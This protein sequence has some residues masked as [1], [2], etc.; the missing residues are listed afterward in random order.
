MKNNKSFS[1]D[2]IDKPVDEIDD[3]GYV[4]DDINNNT[5]SEK[6]NDLPD[7]THSFGKRFRE[8]MADIKEEISEQYR[9]N[10]D[11][12]AKDRKNKKLRRQREF[13]GGDPPKS[14]KVRNVY[15]GIFAVKKLFS[16]I[17]TTVFSLFLIFIL[18]GTIVGTAVAV[19]LLDFM[20]QMPGV[21][22]SEF[23][24]NFGSY[25]YTMNK[26]TEEYELVYKATTSSHEIRIPTNL[27]E[28]PD[29]V[30]FAFVCI[31]D[32]RF[33]SHEGVDFKRT[34]GA[35]IN[36]ALNTLGIERDI[37]GGS[38]ITQQLIKNVT[39]DDAKTWDRKMREIF[40][41][42]KFEK[43]YTKDDILSAYL[44][45]IYFSE[46]DDYQMYGIE[47]ASIG[48][49]GK[50]ASEL[51]IAEAAVLAAIP[52]APNDYNPTIDFELNTK[53]KNTCL[54]KMFELGVI[55]ADQ[56]EEAVAQPILL[57]TMPGFKEKNPDYI[58]L[59]ESDDD[60]RNP[61]VTSWPVDTA[62]NEFAEY[63]MEVHGL[64]RIE[65]GRSMFN[66][67]GYKLYL[68]AD[69]ELQ[70]HLDNKFSTWYHFPEALSDADPDTYSE[71]ERRVQAALAVMD[72]E[73]H[74]LGV[75]GQIGPK[76]ISLGLNRAT[77]SH[78]QPGST[79]K[80]VTTYGYALEN[81]L[82][83]WSSHFYDI[84]L[85]AGVAAE[86][87]WPMNYTGYP[88]KGYYPVDYFLKKS[89]NTLPAQIVNTYGKQAVFD[90]AT[91]KLHLDLDP[92][93][94][95]NY[96]P[97]CVGGT[98]HGP[99]MVNLANAYMPYGNGGLYYKA[100][101]IN[102]AVDVKT[103]ETIID[104]EN[105]Q[106]EQAVSEDTAY[107]MNKLLRKVITEGT[108]TAAQL[109]NVPIAG[110]TGTTENWRDITF[111]GLTPDTV[112][113]LWIGYDYGMNQE[114]IIN[115]NSAEIWRDV[116]GYYANNHVIKEEFPDCETVI[117][118][119]RYCSYSGKIATSGCPGGNH[120]YYKSTDVYCNVH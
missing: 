58:K 9:E 26:E 41:A 34:S 62:I 102:K 94:D 91:Q 108:G 76:T 120:G 79:I 71:D 101:I 49:F 38:T 61:E 106:G 1:D 13:Y 35:I 46:I 55:S 70:A 18:T 63:L 14:K 50:T 98:S 19:Y 111:V 95:L 21:V 56:Y 67:G 105:R 5:E 84:P 72:Y 107:I 87:E 48:Y 53:R 32:E 77:S 52:K 65:E 25:I 8:R 12:F 81:D 115:S 85:A 10:I 88:S 11:D 51:T 69:M 82:I 47:A 30:K 39:R 20:D 7:G 29:H 90:F 24:Q 117:K 3:T 43:N 109:S 119:A 42:M 89:L 75:A 40:T 6:S 57:T 110:K 2:Y 100:S 44:N 28:L 96:S 45:E 83:T 103:G 112:S 80:P 37:Y 114:A 15:I 68:S 74:I 118:N 27:A 54:Y 36:L 33:Y 22:L 93:M 16:I 97:L 23:K 104:N 113:A 116:Y 92:T 78:R 31:E 60:F 86:E 99:T 66:S 64:E 4:Q 17:G 59:T 73:G